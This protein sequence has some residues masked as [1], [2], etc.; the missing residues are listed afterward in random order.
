MFVLV[1]IPLLDSTFRYTFEASLGLQ[2]KALG[3]F[4][5]TLAQ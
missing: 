4:L 5:S 3:V 2:L 1:V